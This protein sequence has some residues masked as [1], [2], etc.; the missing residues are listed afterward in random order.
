MKGRAMKWLPFVWGLLPGLAMLAAGCF[1]V[2]IDRE[3]Q[4]DRKAY[5]T[6]IAEAR[7]NGLNV[8]WLGPGFRAGGEAYDYI[9]G[10]YPQGVNGAAVGALDLV[11]GTRA[12]GGLGLS[13]RTVPAPNWTAAEAA[14]RNPNNVTVDRNEVTVAGLPAELLTY[15]GATT[16]PIDG[17]ALLIQME[18]SGVIVIVP[19]HGSATPGG[20]DLNPLIDLDTFLAVMENLQPYS[21]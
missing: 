10:T 11:Y 8:Y 18:R 21:E 20:P 5:L 16:R 6:P 1:P 19:S 3:I 13:I 9:E 15:S 7:S 12:S 17:Y 14:A 2:E 4:L